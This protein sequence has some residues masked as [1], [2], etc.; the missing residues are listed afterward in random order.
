MQEEPLALRPTY[1]YGLYPTA[2]QRLA[3]AAQ[4]AFACELY[5]AALEQRRAAWRGRRGSIG[6]VGQCR[7]LTDVRAHRMGPPPK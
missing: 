2:R 5:N 7:D 6:Y 3:L 4:L 1:R